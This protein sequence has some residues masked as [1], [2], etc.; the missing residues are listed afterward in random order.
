MKMRTEFEHQLSNKASHVNISI[1]SNN[2]A[3]FER[4][5][6][7]ISDWSSTAHVLPLGSES[8]LNN[9]KESERE[10]ARERSK[11][12]RGGR[13]RREENVPPLIT[14]KNVFGE[15]GSDCPPNLSLVISYCSLV[16]LL[17]MNVMAKLLSLI[18]AIYCNPYCVQ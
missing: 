16:F 3:W 4:F 14:R 10:R 1:T 8:I 5:L 11:Q 9:M 12:R 13:E 18:L 7:L 15:I 2:P 6:A 17:L